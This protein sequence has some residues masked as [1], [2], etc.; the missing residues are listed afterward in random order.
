MAS[1]LCKNAK[2]DESK[3]TIQF[4]DLGGHTTKID[5]DRVCQ[6]LAMLSHTEGHLFGTKIIVVHKDSE[7]NHDAKSGT[8][9]EKPLTLID[10][11]ERQNT[12]YVMERENKVIYSNEIYSNSYFR[13]IIPK[14]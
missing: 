8:K 13:R 7:A 12:Y 3:K 2:N 6:A 1:H 4:L 10:S 9:S 14:E 11:L 5:C